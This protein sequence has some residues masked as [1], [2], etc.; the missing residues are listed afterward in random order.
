VVACAAALYA[1]IG[2]GWVG[3]TEDLALSTGLRFLIGLAG[4]S[5]VAAAVSGA[6]GIARGERSLVVFGAIAF[7][8]LVGGFV[9]SQAL[10]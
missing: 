9:G 10:L 3:W 8:V 1:S 2:L 4:V 5:A 7:G 6:W